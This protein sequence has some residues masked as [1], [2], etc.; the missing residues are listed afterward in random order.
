MKRRTKKGLRLAA[1]G[2]LAVM[3]IALLPVTALAANCNTGSMPAGIFNALKNYG[4]GFNSACSPS[5]VLDAIKGNG[6]GSSNSCTG[7]KC[8]SAGC[9]GSNCT[10]SSCT[11]SN[12]TSGNCTGSNCTGSGCG[13]SDVSNA[14]KNCGSASNCLPSDVLNALKSGKNVDANSL[15]KYLCPNATPAGTSKPTAA[16]TATP[17]PSATPVPTAAPT[18]APTAN[19]GSAASELEAQMVDLINAERAKAG[20]S[21]LAIDSKVTEVARLKSQDMI[22]KGYFSHTSP[23]YGSPF[24]MLKSFGVSYRAAG[25]NIA[26]NRSMTSAHT[27]LMNSSG[28]RQNIL[29]ASYSRIGVGIVTDARGYLY[30]TQMFIG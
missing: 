3:M 29:S 19:P 4:Y 28:H 16:P 23:T 27:A 25:E 18:A 5:D 9:T 1:C 22:D 11:G 10:D 12:C 20:V 15:Y 13:N 14:L 17:K 8:T 24:A 6:S 2:M 7:S 30:I 26:M 21:A